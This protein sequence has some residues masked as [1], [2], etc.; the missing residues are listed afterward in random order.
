MTDITDF[1]HT[2]AATRVVFGQGSSTSALDRELDLLGAS[3]VLV[4]ASARDEQRIAG[5]LA[6]VSERVAGRLTEVRRHVPVESAESGRERAAELGADALLAVGGGSTVGM[7]KAI[8]L[9][10]HLPIVAVPTT[11][12]GSEATPVWG[13]TVDG[14]KTTGIDPVVQPRTVIYDID[15]FADMPAELGVVSGMNALAHSM[16]ALWAPG[17]TPVSDAFAL[18]SIESLTRGMLGIADHAADPGARA[19]MLLGAWLAGSAFATAGSGLHHKI[20]HALGGAFD[21]P[22]AETHAIVLPHVTDFNLAALPD[23]ER[24]VSERLAA[25]GVAAQGVTAQLA[26]LV[27]RVGAPTALA[28]VGL[29]RDDLDR[30]VELAFAKVP[31]ENPRPMVREEM[32]ALIAAALDGPPVTAA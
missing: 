13:L 24:T 20:C 27:R 1:V 4:I 26:E 23:L 5:M 14:I 6:P 8:A 11:Y 16:E 12:S 31:A 17:R 25:A 30:A 7:A 3:R 19:Q 29:D 15:L 21:L 22:H 32:A 2:S 9:T 28:S 18:L 10:H